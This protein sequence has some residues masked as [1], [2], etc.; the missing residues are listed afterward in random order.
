MKKRLY[1]FTKKILLLEHCGET[2][3]PQINKLVS[4]ITPDDL[5]SHMFAKSTLKA[6]E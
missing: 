4:L 5:T 1:I 3:K 6:A 2:S